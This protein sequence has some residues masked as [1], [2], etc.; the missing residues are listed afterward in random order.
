MNNSMNISN[1]DIDISLLK[2]LLEDKE[3]ITLPDD[4]GLGIIFVTRN[5]QLEEKMTDKKWEKRTEQKEWSPSAWKT[6]S[7]SFRRIHG[8]IAASSVSKW[9]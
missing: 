2:S 5:E 8:G 1:A 7:C 3:L 6:V 9:D 4:T